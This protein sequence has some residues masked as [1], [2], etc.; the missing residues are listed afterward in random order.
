MSFLNR[1]VTACLMLVGAFP[2]L[3][4][5]GSIEINT[6]CVADGCFAGDNPGFPVE[7]GSSGSY[8]LT[9]NLQVSGGSTTG[10]AISAS[11][12]TLDLNG[13][14]LQGST[15]CSG[16]PVT[17]CSGT[18]TGVGVDA[19]AGNVIR[20]GSVVGFGQYG[21]DAGSANRLQNLRVE[22][23]G[24]DGIRAQS[25]VMVQNCELVRNGDAGVS[26][27]TGEAMLELTNSLVVGNRNAGAYVASGLIRDNR[28]L[29]NGG[30]GLYGSANGAPSHAA[31]VSNIFIGNDD[32][33]ANGQVFGGRSMGCN[34]IVD[35]V[36]CS[37]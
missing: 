5:D 30:P 32:D 29:N 11:G 18:G 9:S 20:N 15:T 12:V 13:F 3:A 10:I 17:G 33:T 14:T 1:Y 31:Y 37:P 4:D 6:A 2:A 7:I 21:I 24:G 26:A 19:G 8:I 35:T 36:Q 22:Q 25:N 28:F 16:T 27:F 34:M 23:N